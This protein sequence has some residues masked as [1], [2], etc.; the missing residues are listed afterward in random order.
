M[1]EKLQREK[2]AGDKDVAGKNYESESAA[3][4][5]TI[6]PYEREIYVITVCALPRLFFFL[7]SFLVSFFMCIAGFYKFVLICAKYLKF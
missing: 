5:L 7:M 4:K 1:Q 6:S 3:Y 2:L